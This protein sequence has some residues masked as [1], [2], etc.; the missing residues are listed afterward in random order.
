MSLTVPPTS[1]TTPFHATEDDN[2]HGHP[3]VASS[4]HAASES[5]IPQRPGDVSTNLQDDPAQ[6]ASAHTLAIIERAVH[7]LLTHAN[8][9]APGRTANPK[10]REEVA[11]VILSWNA[12]FEPGFVESL[13]DTSCIIA[14][15]AYAHVPYEHQLVIALYTAY[16]VYIDDLSGRDLEAVGQFVRRFSVTREGPSVDPVLERFIVFLQDIYVYYPALS[17]D[18]MIVSTL[19]ALVGRYIEFAARDMAI[20]PGATGYP[21]FLRQKT[22]IGPVYSLFNFIKDWRDPCDNFYLQLIPEISQ[23]TVA[24]NDI[25]SFY[26]E[27]LVEETDN[28][29]HLRAAAEAK[30][31]LHVLSELCDEASRAIH[32]LEAL[33]SSDP[34]TN[35]ICRS[36][37]VG[38]I[39]FYFRADRYKLNELKI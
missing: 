18:A 20:A 31:P 39:E 26:K 7:D 23:C 15:S 37:L 9:H 13:T 36:Y 38:Y 25:L 35:A 11:S 19:D 17:A 1:S 10:L 29:I 12:G 33:T 21:S 2:A 6:P 8:Y 30:D 22:G 3:S 28:Y 5:P 27:W 14:E 24:I 34:E 32:S 4:D 16:V